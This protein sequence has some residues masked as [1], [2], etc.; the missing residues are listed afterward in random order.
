MS[1][2]DSS[3]IT[4]PLSARVTCGW[5]GTNSAGASQGLVGRKPGGVLGAAPVRPDLRHVL[6][7]HQ[8]ARG[9]VVDDRV[10][11]HVLQRVGRVDPE[12]VAAD[13]RGQLPVVLLRVRGQHHVVGAG[14]HG[15]QADEEVLPRT[16]WRV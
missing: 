12:A 16:V 11:G 3:C 13:H 6:A 4:S 2:V 5:S 15:G 9:E 10:A 7:E 14:D 8:I 1:L